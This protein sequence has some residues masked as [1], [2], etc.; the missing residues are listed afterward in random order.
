MEKIFGGL[1]FVEAG[2][3]EGDTKKREALALVTEGEKAPAAHVED[4]A[5]DISSQGPERSPA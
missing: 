5:R 4:V 1:D 3:H 2:E